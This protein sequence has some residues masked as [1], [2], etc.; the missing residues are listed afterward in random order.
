MASLRS[1]LGIAL[2]ALSLAAC[3]TRSNDLTYNPTDFVA[4]DPV[5]PAL[6]NPAYKLSPGDIINVRVF[7]LESVSG[8]QSVDGNGRV[9]MPLIGPVA[10]DG[11]TTDQ[12]GADVARQLGEKYLQSPHVVVTL[13][14]AASR[15]VTV[16]GAVE[17]PGVYPI[18]T[19][20][21]L[22]QTIAM[23]RGASEQANIKRVVIFRQIQG[24]RK[25]AAFDLTTIRRGTDPDPTVYPNDVIVVDGTNLAANY[26]TLLRSVP[27]LGFL[28][29]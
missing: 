25:A 15:V 10:A 11:K 9:N 29:L 3:T 4:P 6:N 1:F 7:E 12:F 27:L 16:D 14:A 13:K 18:T 24:Q 17:Q 19:N 2:A 20:T 8:D 28:G 5:A 22:I 23:A 21:T 26:R